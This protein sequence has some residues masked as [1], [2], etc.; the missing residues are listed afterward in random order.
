MKGLQVHFSTVIF[1]VFERKKQEIS[2]IFSPVD[3]L[4]RV[5]FFLTEDLLCFLCVFDAF[6]VMDSRCFTSQYGG[7]R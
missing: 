4:K 3:I 6:V 7:I 5:L 2:S 1:G